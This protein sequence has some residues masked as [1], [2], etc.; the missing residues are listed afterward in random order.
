MI[1]RREMVF[2]LTGRH[3]VVVSRAETASLG[4]LAALSTQRARHSMLEARLKSCQDGQLVLFCTAVL[5]AE[6]DDVLRPL[7]VCRICLQASPNL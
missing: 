7:F 4:L 2:Q 3:R 5:S 6:G 1:E